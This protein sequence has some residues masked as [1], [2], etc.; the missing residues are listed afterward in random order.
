MVNR[1]LP[2]LSIHCRIFQYQTATRTKTENKLKN[3]L[4]FN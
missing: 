3:E 4:H 1:I 2:V